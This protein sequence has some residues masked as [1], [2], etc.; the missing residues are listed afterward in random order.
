MKFREVF[1]SR[2][3]LLDRNNAERFGS[4]QAIAREVLHRTYVSGEFHYWHGREPHEAPCVDSQV[5]PGD[6]A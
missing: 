6:S 2:A 3:M 1:I 4:P 5:T